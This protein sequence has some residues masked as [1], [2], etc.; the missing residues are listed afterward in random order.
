M[1]YGPRA[2]AGALAAHTRAQQQQ[3]AGLGCCTAGLQ[4]LLLQCCADEDCPQLMSAAPIWA[5]AVREP[6][7]ASALFVEQQSQVRPPK[8]G[9]AAEGSLLFTHLMIR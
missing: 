1:C 6:L 8:T 2:S 3:V 5:G 9:R 4:W 7:S